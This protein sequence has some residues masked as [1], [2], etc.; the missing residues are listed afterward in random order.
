MS[1][2]LTRTNGTTQFT[3][4][5]SPANNAFIFSRKDVGANTETTILECKNSD[6]AVAYFHERLNFYCEVVSIHPDQLIRG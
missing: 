2:L 5:F 4:I 1:T 6:E 3:L